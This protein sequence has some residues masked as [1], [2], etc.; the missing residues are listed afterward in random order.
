MTQ[1]GNYLKDLRLK[2][3]FGLRAFSVALRMDAGNLSRIERS[4]SR[5][6][7]ED[8]FFED[9]ANVLGLDVNDPQI[10]QMRDLAMN[11][12][13]EEVSPEIGGYAK[14]VQLI[15]LL[16]RTVSNKKLSREQMADLIEEIKSNY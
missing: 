13:F 10:V 1:F 2:H 11:E 14:N 6:P 15:P 4:K 7:R 5:P 9:V 12:R 8:V 3:G 16:L